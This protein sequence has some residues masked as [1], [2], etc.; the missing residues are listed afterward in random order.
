MK[1]NVKYAKLFNWN[2]RKENF[3]PTGKIEF[4]G[5]VIFFRSLHLLSLSS[6]E[7]LHICLMRTPS[8]LSSP[9]HSHRRHILF[10][11]IAKILLVDGDEQLP[12]RNFERTLPLVTWKFLETWIP[13]SSIRE[14]YPFSGTY[15]HTWTTALQT[16]FFC[17]PMLISRKNLFDLY[18][19]NL[20][21]KP[22]FSHI[23]LML[24]KII[25]NPDLQ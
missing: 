4:S 11:K 16:S 25:K 10:Y 1:N 19:F 22:Y 18:S 2:I 8:L 17:L 24:K 12:E 23:G 13:P 21:E 14:N 5:W 9:P 3:D 7:T 6:R 20:L 15:S